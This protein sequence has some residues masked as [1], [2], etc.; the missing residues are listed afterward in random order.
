MNEET[1]DQLDGISKQNQ[2]TMNGGP[3]SMNQEK[4][5]QSDCLETKEIGSGIVKLQ[6]QYL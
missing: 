2:N 5:N 6:E 3:Q 4:Q 1:R